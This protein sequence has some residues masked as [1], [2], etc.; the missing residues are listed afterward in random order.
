LGVVVVV[1]VVDDAFVVVVVDAS[2]VTTGSANVD[3]RPI[4]NRIA[5][6]R[7]ID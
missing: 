3:P 2:T 5:S 4:E 6:E 1:E 7:R